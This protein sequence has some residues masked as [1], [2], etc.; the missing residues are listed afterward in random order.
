[1]LLSFIKKLLKKTV[2]ILLLLLFLFNLYGYRVWFYYVQQQSEQRMIT[3]LDKNEY[4][5]ADLITLKVPISL[6][7][8]TNWSDFERY[9][10]SI[11]VDGQHYNYVKRKVCNDTL[12]LLCIP[13]TDKTRLTNAK[14]AY[15]NLING[16]PSAANNGK[17]NNPLA[18]LKLLMSEYNQN[19]HTYHLAPANT[20]SITYCI[21][22]NKQRCRHAIASPWQPPDITC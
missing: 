6:P 22:N 2:T 11:E 5:E 4:N 17:A 3:S 13:N 14:N 21:V 18:L 15:E 10:G 9:D 7:Y 8:F 20:Q 12:V 19:I 16:G 1:L